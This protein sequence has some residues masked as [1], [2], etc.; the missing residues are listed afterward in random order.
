MKHLLHML[1]RSLPLL[2]Q[3][4]VVLATRVKVPVIKIVIAGKPLGIGRR[5]GEN[6]M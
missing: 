2:S 6:V 5:D 1:L 3:S 4:S